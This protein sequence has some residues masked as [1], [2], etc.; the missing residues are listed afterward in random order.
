MNST[1]QNEIQILKLPYQSDAR[2][3]FIKLY[4]KTSLALK[5]FNVRQVNYVEN[6]EKNVFRGLH[7]Q[8][9]V[10][11]ESKLFR[12]LDGFLILYAFCYNR[13]DKNYLKLFSF[14]LSS[15]SSVLVP[16]GYAT[17]YL[18]KKQNTKMHYMS[19]KDFCP[20]SENGICYNDPVL[21]LSLPKSIIVSE[22]DTKW[23][24]FKDD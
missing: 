12:V 23:A 17:G 24:L 13:D 18:V 6:P 21:N 10:H 4:Q 19:N 3:N 11:S 16:E 22:K 2:G 15:K 14:E 20:E 9:G 1:K 8:L 7:Y 5:D